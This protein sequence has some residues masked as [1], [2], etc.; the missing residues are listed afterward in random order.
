MTEQETYVVV[1]ASLAGAKAVE[2]LRESGF[3][4]R[5]VLV[6]D[7][8]DRPYERPLLS[9]ELLK[10]E[11]PREKAYVHDEGWYAEH[12]VELRLGTSATS[13]DR[14]G[15]VVALSDGDH[16]PYDRLLLTTGSSPRRID[17]PGADLDGIHYL[18]RVGESEALRDAFAGLGSSGRLVVVGAGWIGLEVAAAAQHHGLAVTVVEPQAQPLL[19]VLGPEVGAVF[20][21]LH[22]DHDVDL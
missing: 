21:Q 7:E 5:V 20:A 4:G 22:R 14:E 13:V 8:G 10:G 6:G 16:L 3:E 18:R 2:A 11:K 12:D 17:V 15:K 19:G 9:K 1:G